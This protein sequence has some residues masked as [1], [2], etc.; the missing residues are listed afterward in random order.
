MIY[1]ENKRSSFDYTLEEVITAGL[2][3]NGKQT[4]LIRR[5]QVTIPASYVVWQNKRLELI[6][7][8]F[9]TVTESI[10][11]LLDQKEAKRVLGA[12]STKG[13]TVI[14]LRIK[15]VRRWIKVDI[16]IAKG[17]KE[18]EKRDAIKKRDLDRLERTGL[19]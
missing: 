2:V 9:G 14:A 1:A 19:L 11:L 10:P 7:V 12:L 13:K 16:A 18:F 8:G 3:L 17:K 6:N 4:S 15:P 5:R